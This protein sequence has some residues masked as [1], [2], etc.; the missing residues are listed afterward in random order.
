MAEPDDADCIALMAQGNESALQMVC[1]RYRLRLWSYL[2]RQLDG[3][4][5]LAEEALQ[6]TY[7]GVWRGAEQFRG[8][9]PVA[10]WIFRIAHHVAA[11]ARRDLQRRIGGQE[12]A[13]NDE[14]EV[15]GSG[16]TASWET[17]I[18]ERM[19]LTDALAQIS[20]KH[21][22]VLELVGM[23]GFMP[24]EVAHILDI[25]AGT[26]RSRLSYARVALAKA[27]HPVTST[28]EA[29]HER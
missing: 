28:Q 16:D 17:A 13:L 21:R 3:N 2:W 25:A 5:E 1:E 12:V 29:V 24:D 14:D 23:Q 22:E 26:V 27:L 20:P 11:K 4:R 8:T 7:L 6:D 18:L 9:A 15:V 19:T 10:V